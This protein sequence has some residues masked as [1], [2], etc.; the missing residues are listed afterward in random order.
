LE[1]TAGSREVPTEFG[2]EG[3]LK[4]RD[5]QEVPPK[6]LRMIKFDEN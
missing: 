1:K 2:G 6:G 5:H 4:K 3:T